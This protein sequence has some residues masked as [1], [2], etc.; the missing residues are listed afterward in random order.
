[1]KSKK[2]RKERRTFSLGSGFPVYVIFL[3]AGVIFTQA[4]RSPITVVFLWLLILMPFVML[5]YASIT[6]RAIDVFVE[7]DETTA[8]KFENVKYDFRLRNTS[9]FPIPFAEVGLSVPE[10]D[11][12]RCVEQG[13]FMSLMPKGEYKFE[14]TI[15]FRYRGQ[16]HVGVSA[17]YVYDPLRIFC[18]K[19]RLDA[20]NE[21]YVLPRKNQP[22]EKPPYAPSDLTTDSSIITGIESSEAS[23]IRDYLPGDSLKHIHWKLSSKHEEL[24]VNEYR[25][26]SGKNVYVFCDFASIYPDDDVS[27]RKKQKSE[28]KPK[29]Q[30]KKRPVRL[31]LEKKSALTLQNA[32]GFMEEAA[33]MS[34]DRAEA[35]AALEKLRHELKDEAAAD[36]AEEIENA[37]ENE[38]AAAAADGVKA[39]RVYGETLEDYTERF[40]HANDILPRYAYDMDYLCADGVSEIAI[41][42]VMQEIEANNTVT[43][44]WFDGRV[45]AG[46]SSYKMKTYTDFELVF[47][48]FATAPFAPH[49]NCVTRLPDLI[50]DVQNPTFRFVT[51]DAGLET[52]QEF[53]DAANRMGADTTEVILY[54]PIERYV[55]P[56]LRREYIDV[57]RERFAEN[58]IILKETEISS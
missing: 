40:A 53:A 56:E 58:K 54:S 42:I 44:M 34:S 55:N 13:V 11:G 22:T 32:E 12:I 20:Y 8:V 38:M 33:R 7:A 48:R 16:F 27:G 19:R 24:M 57:C 2:K 31:K 51:S 5:I 29:K 6:Y 15:V 14:S 25:P 46:F 36:A 10:A 26:N 45:D 39:S 3:I 21:I 9:V 50:E 4:L 43:L 49:S 30:K 28:N 18:L 37:A 41:S 47:K 35:A 52:V 23:N 17:V 1:M